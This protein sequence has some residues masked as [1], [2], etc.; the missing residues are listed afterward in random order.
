MKT[1]CKRHSAITGD[2]SHTLYLPELGEHYHSTHGALQESLHV[3]VKG[4][5]DHA[6]RKEGL[7]RVLEVGF[8]TGLNA[9]LTLARAAE[10]DTKVAYEA[11]EPFPLKEA[12]WTDLNLPQLLENGRFADAFARMHQAADQV[13]TT[14]HAGF[15]FHRHITTLQEAVLPPNRY[16]VVYHD[17][18]APQYQPEMWTVE[19]FKKLYAAMVPGGVL[20]TYCAK[21]SVKRAM[22]AAGFVLSHPEGPPGK[23]EMTRGH[24][25]PPGPLARG[26]RG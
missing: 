4:G 11:L 12:E 18:F 13:M 6:A 8:G 14:I 2:G 3:F 22:R 23:R 9:L 17:A 15:R 16:H 7:L 24:A 5:F 10:G 20:A 1:F 21:G 25:L 19:V 26:F